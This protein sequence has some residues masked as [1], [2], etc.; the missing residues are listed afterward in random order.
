MKKTYYFSVLLIL[1]TLCKAEAQD[2]PKE[3]PWPRVNM[4]VNPAGFIL[5]GPAANIEFRLGTKTYAGLYYLNHYLG[6]NAGELIF[7][8]TISSFSSKSMGGGIGIRHYFKPNT[9]LNAWYVGLSVGYSYNEASYHEGNPER[10]KVEKVD[11][12]PIIASGGYR[13]N[14]G[15]RFYLNAGLQLGVAIAAIDKLYWVYQ[16]NADLGV[17]EEKQTVYDDYSGD[18]YPFINPELSVGVKF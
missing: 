10:E 1:I 12:V 15:K 3:N 7:D 2:A 14:L 16:Y 4:G 18:V 17:Y 6:I 11:N 13:W 5:I 8:N 9:R